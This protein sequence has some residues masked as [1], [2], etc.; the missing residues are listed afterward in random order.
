[1]RVLHS[2]ARIAALAAVG[3][4]IA[5]GAALADKTLTLLTWNA[6][7]NEPMFRAWIA[8]F[9]AAHPGVKFEWLDK[10]GS[11]WAAFYQTQLV[12]G[13]PPDIVDVQGTLWAQYAAKKTILD[14]T[15]YLKKEPGVLARYNPAMLDYWTMDGKVYGL[16][17]YVNKTLLYYNKLLFAK[18]GLTAPPKTF[19]EFID[20]AYKLAA[21]SKE[22]T[23][24]LGLNFDWM[25][26]TMFQIN[27]VDMFA[28]DMKKVAFNTP[29][30]LAALQRLAKATK[31]GAIN[32]IAWTGRWRE[33]NGAFAS[34]TVGMYQAHGGAYYNFR[35]MGDWINKD[36]VGAAEFPEGWGVLNS[37]GF[38]VSSMTKYPDLAWEFVKQ[39][40]NAKWAKGT[41]KRIIRTTGNMEADEELLAYLKANDPT[42]FDI[43]TIQG[44]SLDKLTAT[45]KT[46]L[47]AKLK[48]AIWPELQSALLGQKGPQE[49]LDAAEKKANRVLH[50]AR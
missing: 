45:W 43:M 32:K 34:G 33:P 5:S 23:G 38:L 42:G 20:H 4:V 29:R 27:G 47:D 50:R 22:A 36:T 16:P 37:H 41:S 9:E 14:L 31:D 3:L 15:P 17:Y 21:T 40:T 12:A 7:Q 49:A 28:P 10:K 39:I 24:F 1:M 44:S 35:R 2:V 19:D 18:A 11:Q 46:P 48:E 8:E 6:P 26:W 13:T 30:M 25:F